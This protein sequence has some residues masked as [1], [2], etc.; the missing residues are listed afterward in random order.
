ML[1]G[2]IA[3]QIKAFGNGVI[4]VEIIQTGSKGKRH[5]DGNLNRPEILHGLHLKTLF[6]YY[7]FFVYAEAV[8]IEKVVEIL[9]I[10]LYRHKLILQIYFFGGSEEETVVV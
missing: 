6:V 7:Q 9:R 4:P 3:V 5:R 2:Q 8:F 1:G 10:V